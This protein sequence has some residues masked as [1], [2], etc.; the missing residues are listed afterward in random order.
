MCQFSILLQSLLEPLVVEI[1]IM[2]DKLELFFK[3]WISHLLEV[4]YWLSL[5]IYR[6]WLVLLLNNAESRGFKV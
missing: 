5:F 2:I 6:L 4:I 3:N 1:S